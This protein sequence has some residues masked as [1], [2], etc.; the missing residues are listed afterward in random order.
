MS[1]PFILIIPYYIMKTVKLY[2]FKDSVMLKMPFQ[3]DDKLLTSLNELMAADFANTEKVTE[4]TLK[5][6]S[7]FNF[8]NDTQEQLINLCDKAAVDYYFIVTLND[9]DVIKSMF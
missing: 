6:K 2:R 9:Y 1:C 3:E 8:E 5:V 4:F 7:D